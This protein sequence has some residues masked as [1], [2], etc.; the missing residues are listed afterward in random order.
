MGR[1]SVAQKKC[2]AQGRAMSRLQSD[3]LGGPAPD[4]AGL[5][6]KFSTYPQ[7]N[8]T[9]VAQSQTVGVLDKARLGI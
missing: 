2:P 6:L 9:F 5:L 8:L 3:A 4:N 1:C 7:S